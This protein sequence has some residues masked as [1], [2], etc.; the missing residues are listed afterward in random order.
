MLYKLKEL[1]WN[2]HDGVKSTLK[3]PLIEYTIRWDEHEKQYRVTYFEHV[4]QES[5]P[6]LCPSLE[7]AKDWAVNTHM[8]DK[9]LRWFTEVDGGMGEK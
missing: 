4:T 9:M 2:D 1:K 7:E 8:K 6:K 5:A 3:T